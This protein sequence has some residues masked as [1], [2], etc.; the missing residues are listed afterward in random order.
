MGSVFKILIACL[1]ILSA[2][3]YG[4]EGQ[5]TLSRRYLAPSEYNKA[6]VQKIFDDMSLEMQRLNTEII[7]LKAGG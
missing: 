4:G 2:P 7:K 6:E 5:Q 3:C 1:A